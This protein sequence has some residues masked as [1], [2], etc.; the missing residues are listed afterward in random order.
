MVLLPIIDGSIDINYCT[1]VPTDHLVKTSDTHKSIMSSY[2]LFLSIILFHHITSTSMHL[3]I[4]S[5]QLDLAAARRNLRLRLQRLIQIKQLR[6][7]VHPVANQPSPESILRRPLHL[8]VLQRE[9]SG[10]VAGVDFHGLPGF[11]S[12]TFI[13]HAIQA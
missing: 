5:L 6:R 1:L 8:G 4:N 2:C 11:T 12:S 9:A 10:A 7:I 3:K 13:P